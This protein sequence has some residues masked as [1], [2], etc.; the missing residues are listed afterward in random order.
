MRTN[1]IP[2]PVGIFLVA[3]ALLPFSACNGNDHSPSKPTPTATVS[4]PPT[5]TPTV[6]SCDFPEPF[7]GGDFPLNTLETTP[8]G[9]AWADVVTG[10]SALLPCFGPYALCYYSDCTKSDDGTV[11]SCPCFDWF[12][13][14]FVDINGILNLD[15]Y[16]ETKALCD[17]DSAACR[18]VNASPVCKQV[19]AGTFLSGAT[20]ISTFSF[21]RADEEPIGETNCTDEPGLYSGCMTA[22]CFGSAVPDPGTGTFTIT[23]DCPNYDGPFQLGKDGQDCHNTSQMTWSAS[24]N[25]TLPPPNPCDMVTGCVPDAPEGTC[26]CPLYDP[27]STMLPPDSGIDCNKVCQEYSSCVREADVELGYTCDATLCTSNDHDLV[28]DACLGLEKCELSEIFKAE[29][30]AACSCCASQL[31]GCQPNGPTNV[32]IFEL[33]ADEREQGDTPQ[34]D[35]NGTLCGSPPP[36]G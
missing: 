35:I 11:S 12:G 22:P 28:F 25:P 4:P 7:C 3:L 21:Y 31:C 19:N 2:A 32:K 33:N 27:G 15:S 34:C 36:E 17:A 10:P 30:A 16:V 26:G 23:C 1:H 20:R 24:Y 18:Q 29:T 9:P 8:Y 14:S 6:S 5:A 13:P